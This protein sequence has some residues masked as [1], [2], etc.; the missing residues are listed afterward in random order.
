MLQMVTNISLITDISRRI[1]PL[2]LIQ[3]SLLWT[4][5]ERERMASKGRGAEKRNKRTMRN[6][7]F[8][9]KSVKRV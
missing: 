5:G 9:R 2:M 8:K 6:T 7:L 3:D 1:E 4:G